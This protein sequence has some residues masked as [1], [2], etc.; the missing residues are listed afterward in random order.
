ML[1][2]KVL[3]I[4]G[5]GYIGSRLYKH[6]TAAGYSVDV[7]DTCWFG[8]PAGVP[9]IEKDMFALTSADLA[10]YRTVV[11]L[12]GHSSVQMCENNFYSA[13]C[14]N[15]HNFVTLLNKLNKHQK[16]IYASSSSVY[17]CHDSEYATEDMP[18]SAPVNPYDHTKQLIDELTRE[19]LIP[20]SGGRIF[21][22][23]F[24]TVCGGSDNFRADVMINAMTHTGVQEKCVRVFNGDTRRSILG[25]RDLC[26]AIECLIASDGPSQIY[27]LA[28]FHSTSIQIG[29]SVADYMEIP[30]LEQTPP[31]TGN[32][33]MISKNYDFWVV[34]HQFEQD[35]DFEFCDTPQSIITDILNSYIKCVISKRDG[36]FLYGN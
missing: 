4:G 26:R 7:V 14:N 34:T 13:W 12:A 18:L 17:G 33:K 22:L 32:A 3:I 19:H 25:L 9:V 16:L 10:L 28:S 8:N 5:A 20:R 23:R 35:M 11:L 31:Q 27:N 6:L 24:G 36:K 30:L 1:T 21:G 15:V 2:D 29:K